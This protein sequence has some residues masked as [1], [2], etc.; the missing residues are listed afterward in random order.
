MLWS[1]HRLGWS[2]DKLSPRTVGPAQPGERTTTIIHW[3]EPGVQGG[4]ERGGEHSFFRQL[5]KGEQRMKSE[6]LEDKARDQEEERRREL[7]RGRSAFLD[8]LQGGGTGVAGGQ[9][10]SLTQHTSPQSGERR[11]IQTLSGLS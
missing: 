4:D 10:E 6:V 5:K 11:P 1:S 2:G 9:M 3:P 7:R 8:R